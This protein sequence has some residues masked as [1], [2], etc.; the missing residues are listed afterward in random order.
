MKIT[1]KELR[2][3]IKEEKRELIKE[4]KAA[5]SK[6]VLNEVAPAIA[7][8]LGGGLLIALGTKGGRSLIAKILRIQGNL[9]DKLETIDNRIARGMGR[10]F[11]LI[12]EISM[13]ATELQPGRMAMDELADLLEGLT[14]EEGAALNAALEPVKVGTP[15]GRIA[16]GTEMMS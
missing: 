2:R 13:I 12:D 15:A 6:K 5:S 3:I 11:P 8:L 10:E 9:L 7:V 16:K 4:R 14:D 1:K